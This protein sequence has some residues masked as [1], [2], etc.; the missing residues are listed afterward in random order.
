MY[1]Q[2]FMP[3]WPSGLR[4][5]KSLPYLWVVGIFQW[6]V[7]VSRNTQEENWNRP[8]KKYRGT[9]KHGCFSGWWSM[10]S[11]FSDVWLFVT[12]LTVDCQAP[13][14][15]GFSRQDYCSGL[16][17]PPPGDLPDSG[18]EPASLMSPA[19]A[20]GFFTTSATWEAHDDAGSLQ[21][22]E[23]GNGW[24]STRRHYGTESGNLH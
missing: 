6:Y 10:L 5:P 18:I 7:L 9:L 2:S 1:S 15:R 13:P 11:H 23:L 3:C 8:K 24:S 4:C 21:N 17:C 16:P 14:S 12:L 22:G 19:L 20:G